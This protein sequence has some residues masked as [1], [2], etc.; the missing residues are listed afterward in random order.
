LVDVL[1]AERRFSFG[2]ALRHQFRAELVN[3]RMKVDAALQELT[4][5]DSSLQRIEEYTFLDSLSS[6]R[7]QVDDD[8][9]SPMLVMNFYTNVIFRISPYN[10]VTAGSN[11]LLKSVNSELVTQK[12]LAEMITYLGILRSSVYMQLHLNQLNS[13]GI[14][15]MR[16]VYDIYKSF[17]TEL[18]LKGSDS[19]LRSYRQ[20]QERSL[21]RPTNQYLE[22]LFHGARADSAYSAERWWDISA[23]AVDQLRNLQRATMKIGQNGVEYLYEQERSS[24]NKTLAYLILA[25]VLVAFILSA[26]ITNITRELNELNVSA[27]RIARGHTG[28]RLVPGTN[29]VVGSLTRS[30]Q[31]I[32][33]ANQQL[34]QA[35]DA[36]GSG[37]FD[38]EVQ[39][40]SA[41]DVLGS[42]VLRM[43]TDLQQYARENEEKLWQ[44]EGLEIVNESVRGD[45]DPALLA[46]DILHTAA[47]YCGAEV[48][49]LY[50]RQD[51]HFVH[52]A[53]FAVEDASGVPDRVAMGETLVGQ[54]AQ[55]RKLMQ[56]ANVPET[57]IKVRS[58]LGESAPGQLLLLPLVFNERTEG[59]LELGSLQ[60]FDPRV[61]ALLQQLQYSLGIAL[62]TARNRY[63]M[64]ELL[65]ETQAQAEELQAQHQELENINAELEA[66]AEKLQASEEELRVQ[67]EELMEANQELE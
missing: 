19:A 29:D 67:Q 58:G 12:L 53:S 41:E 4:Q 23:S 47:E 6:I 10:N 21:L 20:L 34:A 48:G 27:Q 3:Q 63:R 25:L 56:L 46:K 31:A 5:T 7:R 37:R 42:A 44:A 2:Y 43:K 13:T 14:E 54:V 39:A 1:Q 28:L 33:S 52:R 9:I 40:R 61:I 35:A 30:M 15:G 17:E 11:P 62:H 18:R 32:D 64:Q 45:K 36:I 50:V 8:L 49:L 22:G 66:Q 65:G 51:E 38:V 60:P 16:G 57:F 59:V 26:V 55:K 24:R